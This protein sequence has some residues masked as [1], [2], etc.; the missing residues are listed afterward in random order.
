MHAV[1]PHIVMQRIVH[2]ARR[3]IRHAPHPCISPRRLP[4]HQFVG[5]S[6]QNY[7]PFFRSSMRRN[8][9]LPGCWA[10]VGGTGFAKCQSIPTGCFVPSS[11]ANY[12]QLSIQ[13]DHLKME[14]VGVWSLL[15]CYETW[16]SLV[17]PRTIHPS[18]RWDL[19]PWI[20]LRSIRHRLTGLGGVWGLSLPMFRD[21]DDF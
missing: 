21:G 2:A 9:V 8:W 20:S 18:P 16:V 19:S 17:R 12:F 14:T 13:T 11:A 6:K 15:L 4:Y 3:W 10:M 7:I 5:R 1:V